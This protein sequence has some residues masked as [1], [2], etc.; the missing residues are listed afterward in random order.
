MF[1]SIDNCSLL[2]MPARPDNVY[3]YAITHHNNAA[4]EYKAFIELISI[5]ANSHDGVAGI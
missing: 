2:A 3:Y 1:A 4:I 5:I